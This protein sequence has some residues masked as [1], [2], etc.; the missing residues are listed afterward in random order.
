MISHLSIREYV[1]G[2]SGRRLGAFKTAA[3]KCGL[4]LDQYL[5]RIERGEKRCTDCEQW[6][7]RDEFA[8]DRSRWDGLA[9]KCA[10]CASERGKAGHECVPLEDLSVSGPP[11]LPISDGDKVRARQLVNMEVKRGRRP[12]PN[13]LFC[14]LCGHLGDDRRHEYHHHMGYAAE[15]VFDV[16]AL[17]S[18]CHANEHR[19]QVESRTR[20]TNGCFTG[21]ES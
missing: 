10:P 2:L 1:A 21:K 3:A 13:S 11:R 12:N 15:H 5:R 18:L 19:E 17:C 9:T 8:V 14:A 16:I 20:D 6:K 4:T 7:S